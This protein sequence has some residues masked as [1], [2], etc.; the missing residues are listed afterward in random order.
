[1]ITVSDTRSLETDTGGALLVEH[2]EGAGHRVLIREIVTD[3]QEQIRARVSDALADERIQAI[4]LTGGTGVAPRD[5]TPEAIRPLLDREI[6]GFGELF[7][8]L[9]YKEIGP[10]AL[11]SRAMAGQVGRQV[12]FALP[13]SRGALVTAMEKLILPEIGHLVGE[14]QPVSRNQVGRPSRHRPHRPRPRPLPC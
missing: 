5:V 4:L 1:M 14:G 6:P 12:V 3:D 2:L 7:R 11:L 13:G 9:S 8:M 10:A